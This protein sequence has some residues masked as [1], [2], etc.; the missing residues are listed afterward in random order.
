MKVALLFFP[1][2][3]EERTT[4]RYRLSACASRKPLASRIHVPLHLIHPRGAGK[5]AVACGGRGKKLRSTTWYEGGRVWL[6]R[7]RAGGLFGACGVDRQPRDR[8]SPG[9]RRIVRL[10]PR[11]FRCPAPIRLGRSAFHHR[12]F[13]LQIDRAAGLKPGGLLLDCLINAPFSSFG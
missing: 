11:R 8:K 12:K 5:Q 4:F 3:L 10:C 9:R 2:H 7:W 13:P 1:C 6:W